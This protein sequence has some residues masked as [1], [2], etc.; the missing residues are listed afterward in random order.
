MLLRTEIRNGI[1]YLIW[2]DQDMLSPS[3]ATG[4]QGE[5]DL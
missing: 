4:P 3:P 2:D 5:D 1:I